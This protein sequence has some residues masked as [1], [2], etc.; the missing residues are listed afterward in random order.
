M[1]TTF[2]VIYIKIF[3][4]KYSFVKTDQLTSLMLVGIWFCKK[5]TK[6]E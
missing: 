6:Y 5:E 4:L 2:L 1:Q 3:Y